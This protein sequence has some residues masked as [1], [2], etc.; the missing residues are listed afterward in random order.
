[1]PPMPT[2]ARPR[3]VILCVLDGWGVRTERADNAI[4]Q[5][6]TPVWNRLM[7]SFPHGT[8]EASEHFVGL[9][10]GQMGNSEVGH[11]NLGAGRVVM[12]DLPRIDKALA[13]GSLATNP[14]LQ[15]FI[16]RLKASRGTCQLMGLVSPG[17]VHSH[18]SHIAGLARILASAGIPVAI[19]AFLDG[20]DT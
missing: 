5:A 19:H 9:P 14:Q 6:D 17:G 12:Q 10:D 15:D 4:A 20:R 11:M 16:A 1:M 13:D 8:L 2:P 3:P 7:A 18:Q